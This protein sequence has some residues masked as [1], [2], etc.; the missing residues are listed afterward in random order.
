VFDTLSLLLLVTMTTSLERGRQ[1]QEDGY[2]Y[3]RNFMMCTL[4][5]IILG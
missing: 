5:E 1:Q 2:N 3:V 4:H